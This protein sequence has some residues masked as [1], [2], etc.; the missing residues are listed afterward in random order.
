MRIRVTHASGYSSPYDATYSLEELFVEH[1]VSG[2]EAAMQSVVSG[3]PESDRCGLLF[4]ALWTEGEGF[5]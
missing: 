3:E 5:V 1:G 2:I 4:E